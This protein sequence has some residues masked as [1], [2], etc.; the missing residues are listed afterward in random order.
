MGALSPESQVSEEL[1]D[2]FGH[3]L[4]ESVL[5]FGVSL[6]ERSAAFLAGRDRTDFV[7]LLRRITWT[8]TASEPVHM[9]SGMPSLTV[10][11]RAALDNH[12]K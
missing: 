6:N 3:P 2:G 12:R 10:R 7:T 4:S 11:A 9:S 5:R 1:C 8:G